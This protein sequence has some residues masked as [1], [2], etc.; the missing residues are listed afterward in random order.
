MLNIPYYPEFTLTK[1][2]VYYQT[3]LDDV[4][5]PIVKTKTEEVELYNGQGGFLTFIDSYNSNYIDR[6]Y[7]LTYT[8]KYFSI[9]KLVSLIGGVSSAS[10]FMYFM[11]L[12]NKKRFYEKYFNPLKYEQNK[13]IDNIS[14][15]D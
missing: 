1:T 15:L 14:R 5:N 3:N 4:E 6:Y 2:L 9:A 13:Y 10:L 8:P 11:V 12:D 7:T